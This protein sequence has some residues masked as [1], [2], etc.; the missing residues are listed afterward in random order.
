[1]N[2]HD[3]DTAYLNTM[4]SFWSNLFFGEDDKTESATGSKKP[5]EESKPAET[6]TEQPA[7]SYVKTQRP[8][9]N[10]ARFGSRFSMLHGTS[11]AALTS[12]AFAFKALSSA[13][14]FF[15]GLSNY[16]KGGGDSAAEKT[17]GREPDPFTTINFYGDRVY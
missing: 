5:A 2:S 16:F 11:A 8:R 7:S 17:A 4:Y 3:V 9:M 15:A 6:K 14:A 12:Y 10:F 13:S 1:M